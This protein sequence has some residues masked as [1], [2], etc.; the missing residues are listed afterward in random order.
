MELFYIKTRDYDYLSNYPT[1]DVFLNINGF[2]MSLTADTIMDYYKIDYIINQ[3][4]KTRICPTV[5]FLIEEMNVNEWHLQ[6]VT[7]TSDLFIYKSTIRKL[8]N[9]LKVN[10]T[11]WADNLDYYPKHLIVKPLNDLPRKTH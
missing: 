9:T 11:V 3:T 6:N 4:I 1:T 7:F 2:F 10:G 5:F 8:P